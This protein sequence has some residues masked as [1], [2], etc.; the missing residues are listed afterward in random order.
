MTIVFQVLNLRPQMNTFK[1]AILSLVL[2]FLLKD[3]SAQQTELLPAYFRFSNDNDY[4]KMRDGTDRYYTNG[5]NLE[6]QPRRRQRDLGVKAAFPRLKAFSK[7]NTVLRYGFSMQAFTP[8]NPYELSGQQNS[9]P[10]CGLALLSLSGVSNSIEKQERL[11][12]SYSMGMMGPITHQ[13]EMQL[14]YHQKT[15]RRSPLGWENQIANDL[16]LNAGLLYEKKMW[17]PADYLEFNV[18]AEGNCGTVSNYGGMGLMYRI[19]FFNDYFSDLLGLSP[20]SVQTKHGVKNSPQQRRFQFYFFG[21]SVGRLVLDNS[22]LEAGYFNFRNSPYKL[23]KQQIEKWYAQFEF[24]YVLAARHFS[25]SFSQ[26]FRTPEFKSGKSA[27]WGN[28]SFA[29]R[30]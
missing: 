5:F 26:V 21:K 6:F 12:T 4:Y 8:E 1:I 3:V 15:G 11:T 23:E 2:S 29:F 30:L 17:R 28:L 27:Q 16:A 24:G 7:S 14:W 19:G 9:R 18:L 22:L 20:N 25:I 10:Y 13:E